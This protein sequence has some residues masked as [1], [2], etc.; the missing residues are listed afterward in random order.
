MDICTIGFSKKELRDFIKR[1]K[2]AGVEKVIDIRLNN[3]SQ[4]AGY[5]KKQD[6]QYVLELVEIEYEHV[7]ELAPTDELMKDYKEKR[8]SWEEFRD[9]YNALLE[10]RKPLKSFDLSRQPNIICLLCAEDK[11]ERCHRNLAAQYLKANYQ[12]ETINIKHL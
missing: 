12:G 5:A 6:L 7:L 11:P 4:L 9:I 2:D 10:E 3:T 8:I 1:L